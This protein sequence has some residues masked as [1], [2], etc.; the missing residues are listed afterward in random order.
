MKAR[1]VGTLINKKFDTDKLEF[2][3]QIEPV[4]P[5]FLANCDLLRRSVTKY[6]MPLSMLN[7]VLFALAEH[8]GPRPDAITL[9]SH[10]ITHYFDSPDLVLFCDHRQARRIRYKIRVRHYLDRKLSFT[11]IKKRI[12]PSFTEKFRQ[13]KEF[14]ASA[15]NSEEIELFNQM[16]FPRQILLIPQLSMEFRRLTLLG[17]NT[18]ERITFDRNLCFKNDQRSHSIDNV[19]IIEV[20]QKRACRSTFA[21]Q[22]LRKYSLR[23][24]SVSKYCLGILALKDGLQ[25]LRLREQLRIVERANHD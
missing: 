6:V 13:T 19:V 10:Y 8:Y 24:T 4:A 18:I 22:I 2:P 3:T 9:W 23:P 17:R 16:T 25:P 14:M 7:R 20:K 1:F 15:L 5:H 12:K 21:L 11:E